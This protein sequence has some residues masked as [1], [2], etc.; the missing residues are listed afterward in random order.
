MIV[1]LIG[2]ITD[3]TADKFLDSYNKL[4]PD[5]QLTI[6]MSSEGGLIS[7]EELIVDIVN[8]QPAKFRFIFMDSIFSAAFNIL[9]R[10]NCEKVVLPNSLGMIHL[11]RVSTDVNLNGAVLNG[12]SNYMSKSTVKFYL[13]LYRS[14][15]FTEQDL[16]DI[17]GEG[18][19]YVRGNKLNKIVNNSKL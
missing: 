5:E 12:F 8:D 1:S 16:I 2:G 14:V 19:V 13:D 3:K 15:G 4:G 10:I 6:Y 18:D 17:K 9:L 11:P 7:V